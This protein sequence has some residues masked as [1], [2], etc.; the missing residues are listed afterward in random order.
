MKKSWTNEQK[1][2]NARQIPTCSIADVTVYKN[3]YSE[4]GLSHTLQKNKKRYQG[5][6]KGGFTL[7]ELLVVIVIVGILA[8]VAVPQYQKAV[9]RA[10]NREAILALRIIGRGIE[11]YDLANGPLP[12]E[13]S[14]NFAL[15]DVTVP[16][17]S[18]WDYS[19]YCYDE[20][21]SCFVSANSKYDLNEGESKYGLRLWIR[22]GSMDTEIKVNETKLVSVVK[23][24]QGE[25]IGS[26]WTSGEAS[27]QVCARAGGKRKEVTD[28]HVCVLE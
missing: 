5:E 14:N 18:Y 21:K 23:N 8:A 1:I 7:I 22:Q 27:E 25:E 6:R 15:L 12:E 4:P 9:T 17:S 19:F 11:F 10:K 2:K 13:K 26:N 24:E 28:G 20:F 3:D 16:D